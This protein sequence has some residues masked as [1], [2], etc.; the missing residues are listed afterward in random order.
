MGKTEGN[1][2]YDEPIHRDDAT[3]KKNSPGLSKAIDIYLRYGKI[4]SDQPLI[5]IRPISRSDTT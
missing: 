5:L 3:E 2:I 1:H 4:E